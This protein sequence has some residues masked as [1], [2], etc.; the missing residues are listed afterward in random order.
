MLRALD[1]ALAGGHHRE[2]ARAY[3]NLCGILGDER[4]FAEAEKYIELGWRTGSRAGRTR[5]GARRSCIAWPR[6]RASDR[7]RLSCWPG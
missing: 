1:I 7:Q 4:E 3:A 2:T 5:P 6:I